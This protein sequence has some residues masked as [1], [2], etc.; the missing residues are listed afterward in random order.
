MSVEGAKKENLS[1]FMG[2]VF[3][4]ICRQYLFLPQIYVSLPFPV[5]EIG[6]WWGN[7]PKARR[8]EEIDLMSVLDKKALFCECIWRCEKVDYSVMDTLLE[9][10]ELFTYPEKHYYIFSKSGFTDE[11]KAFAE[12]NKNVTLIDFVS[13]YSVKE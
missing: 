2:Q 6:R 11:V 12:K 1:D 3:E 7:N 5:G 8:K 9:R 13:M 4:E 10:G